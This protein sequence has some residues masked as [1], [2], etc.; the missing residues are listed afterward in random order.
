MSFVRPIIASASSE[1]ALHGIAGFCHVTDGNG[2]RGRK[3]CIKA[4][5]TP[6]RIDWF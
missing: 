1:N 5:D 6:E 2:K 4:I 3:V